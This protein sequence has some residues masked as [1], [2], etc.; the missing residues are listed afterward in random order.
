MKAGQRWPVQCMRCAGERNSEE[1]AISRAASAGSL[2]DL[3]TYAYEQGSKQSAV[4]VFRTLVLSSEP[5]APSRS[6]WQPQ[7]AASAGLIRSLRLP[8]PFRRRLP[9]PVAVPQC[10]TGT[11]TSF[12][13][14][15]Q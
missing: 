1:E 12:A 4:Q 15:C 2:G 7:A 3:I 6:Q 5:E 8:R 10:G 14:A 11:G 9:L 13:Q